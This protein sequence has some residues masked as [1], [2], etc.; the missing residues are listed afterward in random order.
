MIDDLFNFYRRHATFSGM[1]VLRNGLLKNIFFYILLLMVVVFMV[2]SQIQD[3]IY[4]LG[5]SIAMVIISALTGRWINASTVHQKYKKQYK[6]RLN[7]SNEGFNT[8]YKEK[9]KRYLVRS[10]KVRCFS[11]IPD[12]KLDKIQELIAERAKIEK[13]PFITSFSVFLTLFIP[14]WAIYLSTIFKAAENDQNKA[15][16]L[17]LIFFLL[18]LS[19]GLIAPIIV[20]IRD[21]F[22]SRCHRWN[23]LNNLLKEI[24]MQY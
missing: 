10:E 21:S 7:W 3:N 20:E 1:V 4:F 5:G 22:F 15:G 8:I 11:E 17:F 6:S 13:L 14:L 23:K 9:I 16:I 18:I 19:I 24:R 12:E 2:V